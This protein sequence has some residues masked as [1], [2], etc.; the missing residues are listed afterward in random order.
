MKFLPL[1]M[2]TLRESIRDK[3]LYV[4]LFFALMMI[5]SGVVLSSLSLNQQTK[6]V[7]D[8]GLSSI[9]IFGLILTVFVGTSMVSKEVDKKTIYLLLSKPLRRRDFILGKFLGLSLTLFVIFSAMALCFYG[10]LAYHKGFDIAALMPL[11]PGTAA[12]LLLIYVEILLLIAAAIFFSTFATP[13]MSAMFTLA[14]Y[15]IG[16]ASNDI[17]AFAKA[18]QGNGL[19]RL[20]EILFMVLPDLER[21]NL[22]NTFLLEGALNSDILFA[23]LGYGALYTLS[24]L[25]LSMFIFEG[26]EF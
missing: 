3:L 10:V 5:G 12:T 23:S 13:V 25:L 2:N 7:M 26:R 14:V 17:L 11:L 24:L 6:I 8:L 1:A 16:H 4:I 9:S 20:L 22:K 21:L 18:N 15:L 19:Q